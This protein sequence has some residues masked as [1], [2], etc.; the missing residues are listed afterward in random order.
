M[1]KVK[2]NDIE[3]YY[4]IHGEG[5]KLVYVSG[6]G[7]DLRHKP[8]VFDGP[9]AQ[10][11]KILAFDQRGMGQNSKP[12]IPYTMA[13]YAND[14]ARLM[15]KVG[16]TSARMIGSSFGGMVA[17]EIAINYP[18]KVERL[19]LDCT[20]SGGEGGAS[21]PLHEYSHL[22]MEEFVELLISTIDTRQNEEWRR[23]NP[24][25]YQEKIEFWTKYFNLGD[26]DPEKAV[27]R[28]RQLEAR[29]GHDTYDRLH[30]LTMPVLICGGKY[31]GIAPPSNLRNIHE[32]IPGSRLEFFEGGHVYF[33]QDPRAYE[34]IIDFLKG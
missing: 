8:N 3:M 13:D 28:K 26:E 16:W 30:H 12:D 31:D 17:Q 19:V 34:V 2:V 20:S 10:H 24:E 1:P 27:G 32:R 22:P 9:F 21:Y 23:D 25:K 6:T 15:E 18:K 4:E 5:P 14:A 7:G 33:S 29:V 11:F